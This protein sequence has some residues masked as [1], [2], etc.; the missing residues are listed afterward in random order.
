MTE[1][2]KPTFEQVDT[3]L[4]RADYLREAEGMGKEA[5]AYVKLLQTFE[6]HF[7]LDGKINPDLSKEQLA[8]PYHA[9]DR[10]Y[11]ESLR[12]KMNSLE[13]A[14]HLT[15]L[16]V[17]LEHAVPEK[18]QEDLRSINEAQ[19]LLNE[20]GQDVPILENTVALHFPVASGFDDY[21]RGLLHDDLK[22]AGYE[23]DF[24]QGVE[25]LSIDV[26]SERASTAWWHSKQLRTHLVGESEDEILGIPRFFVQFNQ[27]DERSVNVVL[28]DT[29]HPDD[30]RSTKLNTQGHLDFKNEVGSF[31]EQGISYLRR[32]PEYNINPDQI[33]TPSPMAE[34]VTVEKLGQINIETQH[35]ERYDQLS[36]GVLKT[37]EGIKW[38]ED[39]FGAS[40]CVNEVSI[41]SDIPF[42]AA[43]GGRGG[44][45]IDEK[46]LKEE[47]ASMLHPELI[48]AH[49][50]LHNI[51][52]L[53]GIRDEPAWN[54]V[55]KKHRKKG[56]MEFIREALLYD[57]AQGHPTGS[58]EEFFASFILAVEHPNCLELL[59]P[60]EDG[61]VDPNMVELFLDASKTLLVILKR[62][63]REKSID[64]PFPIENSLRRVSNHIYTNFRSSAL[65]E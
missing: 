34:F 7:G 63:R 41:T 59:L 25:G 39:L 61:D 16:L 23:I 53:Y 54:F 32:L 33:E 51:D 45:T 42:Y 15:F 27:T 35:P 56:S 17:L 50:A 8:Q 11:R 40:N 44:V 64:D 55:F 13:K 26:D 20:R 9:L 47:F 18:I 4:E 10:A 14:M 60:L 49:E 1:I 29:K 5:E 19:Y 30:F 31:L 12:I 21:T 3:H 6:E 28:Y 36:S 58:K 57:V 48:G 37:V 24:L 52:A 22:N 62:V 38:A 46:I 43:T 2:Q 65:D